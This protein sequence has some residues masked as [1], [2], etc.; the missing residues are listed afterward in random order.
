VLEAKTAAFTL[1]YLLAFPTF[2]PPLPGRSQPSPGPIYTCAPFAQDTTRKGRA[3]QEEEQDQEKKRPSPEVRPEWMWSRPSAAMP[4]VQSPTQFQPTFEVLDSLSR[5]HP[6]LK[7]ALLRAA[8]VAGALRDDSIYCAW[9]NN[10]LRALSGLQL[11]GELE[12]E[13][14][15]NQQRFGKTYNPMRG[16]M[17]P[18]QIDLIKLMRSLANLYQLMFGQ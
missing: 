12:A 4:F 5:L 15:L 2:S 16:P 1:L 3:K 7:E 9:H 14:R 17:D 11:P 6:E 8:I 10:Y 13:M 18:Y